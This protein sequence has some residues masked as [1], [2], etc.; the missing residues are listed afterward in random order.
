MRSRP[1]GGPIKKIKPRPATLAYLHSRLLKP[2]GETLRALDDLQNTQKIS[3]FF[4]RVIA[5]ALQCVYLT[6]H[7]CHPFLTFLGIYSVFHYLNL[8]DLT[9]FDA[10]GVPLQVIP[11]IPLG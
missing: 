8:Y 1:Q 11:R 5:Q 9:F 6:N 4:V 10:A 7:F 3:A 2:T